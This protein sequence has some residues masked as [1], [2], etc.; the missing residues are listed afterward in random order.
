MLRRTLRRSIEQQSTRGLLDGSPLARI[1]RF[2]GCIPYL[3]L[4]EGV[5]VCVAV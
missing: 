4:V 1:C 2:A 5:T 3:L